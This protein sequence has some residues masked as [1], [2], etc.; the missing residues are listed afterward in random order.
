MAN[1]FTPIAIDELPA[2]V[3]TSTITDVDKALA[4]A[5]SAILTAG[6]A[7]KSSAIFA[8]KRKATDAGVRIAGII[9]RLATVGTEGIYKGNTS[10]RTLTISEKEFTFAIAPK[11]EPVA[12]VAP[13]DAP[14]GE[15]P[16]AETPAK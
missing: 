16:P 14:A 9:K 7:A 5:V 10:V 8:E 12:E 1:E 15:T 2:R 4:V 11:V 6:Q 13:T 3:R